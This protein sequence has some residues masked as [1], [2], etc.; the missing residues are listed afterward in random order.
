[1]Y[2][3]FGITETLK[4]FSQK[5]S[6]HRR[7]T[8][9]PPFLFT[10]NQAERVGWYASWWKSS[11]QENTKNTQHNHAKGPHNNNYGGWEKK[12]IVFRYFL[13]WK[14]NQYYHHTTPFQWSQQN[15]SLTVGHSMF[16]LSIHKDI[17]LRFTA[18]NIKLWKRPFPKELL[19]RVTPFHIT[20]NI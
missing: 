9:T 8:Y 3:K 4:P 1:M 2:L 14:S 18:I 6:P 20:V 12:D 16:W 17:T 15:R 10:P 13:R 7:L 19:P 5:D 11:Q